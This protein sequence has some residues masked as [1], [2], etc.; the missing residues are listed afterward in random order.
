MVA[1]YR[2]GQESRLIRPGQLD[3]GK[4]DLVSRYSKLEAIHGTCCE[5]VKVAMKIALTDEME[6]RALF[7]A[8]H[9]NNIARFGSSY[10][11]TFRGQMFWKRGMPSTSDN[12]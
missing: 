11:V 10:W 1:T 6:Q 5:M 9:S 7:G 3:Q 4:R 8:P 12:Q 2:L